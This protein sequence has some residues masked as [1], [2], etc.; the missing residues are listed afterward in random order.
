MRVMPYTQSGGRTG[1]KSW[2]AAG[3]TRASGSTT[4]SAR[5]SIT[6]LR[7]NRHSSTGPFLWWRGKAERGGA[8]RKDS[9][10]RVD[11]AEEDLG[12]AVVM[13][14][15]ADELGVAPFDGP[16]PV[17]DVTGGTKPAMPLALVLGGGCV[18]REQPAR[19]VRSEG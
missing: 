15:D 16:D 3:V 14:G 8:G 19:R 12:R 17:G 18:R 10:G 1:W 5:R 13:P 7:G 11:H 4:A 9:A 6:V 2:A